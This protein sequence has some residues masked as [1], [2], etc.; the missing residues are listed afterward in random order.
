MFPFVRR[1]PAAAEDTAAT[2]STVLTSEVKGELNADKQKIAEQ[3]VEIKQNAKAARVGEGDLH[4]QIREAQTAGDTAKVEALSAQLKAT[5]QQN[6]GQMKQDKNELK[7]AKKE[8]RTD[9]RAAVKSRVDRNKD[10]KV[11]AVEKKQAK[12]HGWWGQ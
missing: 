1:V 2:S 6:V 3:K 8:L 9:R 5:H 11:D 12:K 4:K 7:T 10:G